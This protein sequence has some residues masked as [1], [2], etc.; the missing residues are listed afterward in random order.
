MLTVQKIRGAVQRLGQIHITKGKARRFACGVAALSLETFESLN[1][2]GR[3]LGLNRFTG[4]NRIRRAVLDRGLANQVQQLLVHEALGTRT[5]YFYCSLDHS[6]F[7]PFCIAVLAISVRK[8]RAIPIWC[9]VNVSEAALIAP[10]LVALEVL[11]TE[12]AIVAPGLKLV[13]VMDRWFASDTLFKLFTEHQIYFIARTKGD[14][15][16]QLPWDPSWWRE[17]LGDISQKELLVTYRSHR[18][19]FVRSD[20]RDSMKGEEPWLLLT[21]LPEE[22][23]R[24]MVLHRYA[25]RFEI[26]EAFK[27]VKWLQRLKWQRVKKPEV[28]RSLLLFVFL[29]WWLLWRYVVPVTTR[30]APQAMLHPKRQLSWFRQAWEYLQRLLRTSL[31]PPTAVL[32]RGVKK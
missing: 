10:L 26:E 23:T 30:E 14:K 32:Q 19:R 29:G 18:L 3:S 11:F 25:E 4:E 17:P 20:F 12:L 22:I 24:T 9:Q 7:G 13:V 31:L 16:I 2:A 28:I 5:G 15:L 27:D 1:A 6:Q 21:N 8:G